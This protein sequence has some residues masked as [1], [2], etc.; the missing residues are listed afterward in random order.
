VKNNTLKSVS[1]GFLNRHQV[2]VR[3]LLVGIWNTIFGYLV[4]IGLYALFT[5]IFAA[6]FMA[7]M[8]AMMLANIVSI[9]NAYIFHK[10]ITFKSAVKQWGLVTEFFRFSTTYLLTFCFS[11]IVLPVF[12]EFLAFT[13]AIS[14][15]LVIL[16]CS[17]ISYLGHSRFSFRKEYHERKTRI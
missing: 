2:K 9:I 5:R 7:Y 10:F 15:A 14:G 1:Y 6:Q 11:L 17:V 13:P 4:Y 8:T 16:I 12:I 3:F